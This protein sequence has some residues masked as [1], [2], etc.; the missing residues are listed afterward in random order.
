[1]AQVLEDPMGG[2]THG[3]ARWQQP[4][5]SYLSGCHGVTGRLFSIFG[6]TVNYAGSMIKSV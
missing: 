2:C 4:T 5:C 6:I 1:M 3:V